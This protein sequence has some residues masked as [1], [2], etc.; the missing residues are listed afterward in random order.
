[1]VVLGARCAGDDAGPLAGDYRWLITP[2]VSKLA[3]FNILAWFYIPAPG[4]TMVEE[5]YNVGMHGSG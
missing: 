5:V 3:R 4:W 1:M 2:A